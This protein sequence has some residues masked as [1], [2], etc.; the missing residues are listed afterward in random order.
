MDYSILGKRQRKE[1]KTPYLS[2]SDEQDAFVQ[3]RIVKIQS[4]P[5]KMPIV[6]TSLQVKAVLALI[7]PNPNSLENK[8]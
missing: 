6:M 8:T 1:G 2:A 7:N 3:A 5:A 4:Q